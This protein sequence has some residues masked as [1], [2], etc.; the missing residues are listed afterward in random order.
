MENL[1]E[2]LAVIAGSGALFLVYLYLKKL[3]VAAI[4]KSEN[5]IDDLA[6]K[7]LE[8]VIDKAAEQGQDKLIEFLKK[9]QEEEKNKEQE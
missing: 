5:Q 7:A 1:Y 9:K 4:E 8:K 2:I 6:L 3:A